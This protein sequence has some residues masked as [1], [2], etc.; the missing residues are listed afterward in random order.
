MKEQEIRQRF[1][2]LRPHLNEKTKRL[3]AGTEAAVLG[4]GGI[5]LVCRATGIS[6][7][8]IR[9]GKVENSHPET[10][11]RNRIRRPGGGRKRTV[12]KDQ[13]LK[14]DL[15]CLV[16]PYTRGDPESP[17]RWTCKSTRRL[18]EA[19][20]NQHH[21]VSHSLVSRLLQEMEYSLQSNRKT[22]EGGQHPDRNKQF[23]YI[24]TKT[25][26]FLGQNQPVISV[27]T[28]KKEHIGNFKNAGREYCKKGKPV[29]VNVY[30][31]PDPNLGKAVPYGVYDILHNKGWVSVGMNSDTAEFAVNGIRSWWY[32]M[33]KPLYSNAR[34][35][36][37]TADCG[38]SN[39]YRTRLWKTELQQLANE[40]Q[41][42]I[43]V[44]HFPPGTSKWNKIEHRMF[45]FI[46]KNWR[47]KPLLSYVT[48]VNLI[49]NTTTTEGLQIDAIL[50]KKKYEKG[51]KIPDEKFS[52]VKIRK[53][54]FHGEW[55]YSISP[56]N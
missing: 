1:E 46:S 49:R 45:S 53:Y 48:I 3:W 21:A 23:R 31:F 35:F 30:D 28:K 10:V 40:L 38:G 52:Q 22:Q 37:I 2:R 9:K 7:F 33:G 55:N 43:H 20:R 6:R 50:D 25:K 15:E 19:L 13:T 17:L 47:G 29:D 18:A 8:T 34:K 4:R 39:S 44:S 42:T 51:I 54:K 11:P 16:E 12:D 36:F 24:N 5:S 14:A 32:H 56:S 27:D 41:M 26:R